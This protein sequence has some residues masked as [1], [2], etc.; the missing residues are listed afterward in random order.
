MVRVFRLHRGAARIAGRTLGFD[1]FA[2]RLGLT[3]HIH[4]DKPIPFSVRGGTARMSIRVVSAR[5]PKQRKQRY[6]DDL[7]SHSPS[8]IRVSLADKLHNARAIARDLRSA[9]PNA[10]E[11]W[12]RFNTGAE[13][14]IWHY[15]ELVKAFRQISESPMVNELADAVGQLSG[16]GKGLLRLERV[17]IAPS[18]LDSSS[19]SCA[20]FRPHRLDECRVG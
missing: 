8:G 4:G 2:H 13:G 16:T 12:G 6:I 5:S 3:L 7:A 20:A 11:F 10:A 9:G 15:G 19:L 17:E 14:Q 1:G 18:I